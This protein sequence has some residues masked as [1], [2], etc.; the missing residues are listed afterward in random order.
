MMNEPQPRY[1]VRFSRKVAKQVEALPRNVRSDFLHLV[2][3]LKRR[4]PMLYDWQNFSKLGKDEYHCHLSYSWVACWKHDK[5]T[6]VIEVYYA[7]SRQN[8]PY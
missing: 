1:Q 3:D 4:G 8:A 6:I 7:G 5:S 2:E